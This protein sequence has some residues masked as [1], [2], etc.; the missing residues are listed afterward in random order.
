MKNVSKEH[1][2]NCYTISNSDR[3]TKYDKNQRLNIFCFLRAIKYQ[4][5]AFCRDYGELLLN[6]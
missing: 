5:E 1:I 6:V 3:E 2:K 4:I